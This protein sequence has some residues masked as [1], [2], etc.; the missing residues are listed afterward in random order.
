M[1]S[2]I[3]LTRSHARKSSRGLARESLDLIGASTSP[4]EAYRDDDDEKAALMAAEGHTGTRRPTISLRRAS[5]P[6][7]ASRRGLA[8]VIAILVISGG[9]LASGFALGA[10]SVV[11]PRVPNPYAWLSR[12]YD[13]AVGKAGDNTTATFT[14]AWRP[15]RSP[16]PAMHW[17]DNLLPNRR[18]FTH[19]P[20]GGNSNQIFEVR[21]TT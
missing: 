14:P 3:E 8:R 1:A 21:S 16:E 20:W 19:V 10:N 4:L 6:R 7:N 12:Y 2:G 15:V 13:R 9:L 5:D 17:K 18:Y 11:I